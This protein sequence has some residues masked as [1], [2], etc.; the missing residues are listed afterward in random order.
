MI[1]IRVLLIVGVGL[2][3]GLAGC[4]TGSSTDAASP[5]S[6]AAAG[7][8]SAASSAASAAA[9]SASPSGSGA[10]ATGTDCQRLQSTLRGIPDQLEQAATS[11]DPAAALQQTVQR[12]GTAVQSDVSPEDGR[13]HA[14]VQSWLDQLQSAANSA[15]NGELPD[16]S[17]FDTG[18]LTDLCSTTAG[19]ASATSPAS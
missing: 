11:E 9:S 10:S 8:P 2:T 12:I 6:S 5:A 17:Q 13:L 3:M 7:V 14:A 1:R 15:A 4:S 18:Q 19:S 16:L